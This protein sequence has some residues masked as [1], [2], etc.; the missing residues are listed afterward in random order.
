[1]QIC[2]AGAVNRDYATLIAAAEPLGV[3]LKIAADTAWRYTASN[4]AQQIVPEFVEMRS[5]G[6]YTNLR[7]LYASSAVVVV[8]LAKPSLSGVTVL[9]E[10]MAMARPIIVTRNAYIEDFVKDGDNCLLVPPGDSEAMR[11]KIRYL[12]DHPDKASDLG[13]RAREWVLERFTVEHYVSKIL[14]VWQ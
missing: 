5:W 3:E 4:E 6:D 1:M 2:S 12:L 10:A 11:Q 9:L 7:D 8:P 14:S 13:I